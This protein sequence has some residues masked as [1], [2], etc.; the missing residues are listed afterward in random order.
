[1]DNRFSTFIS[2]YLKIWTQPRKT[3][4]KILDDQPG[5]MVWLFVVFVAIFQALMPFFYAPF[6]GYLPLDMLVL[7]GICAILVFDS[8]GFFYFSWMTAFLGRV[9]GGKGTS[10]DL[11][12]AYAWC[13]P[14]F[15][16]ALVLGQVGMIPNW[17]ALMGGETHILALIR[18][19]TPW[20]IWL[21]AFIYPLEF[22]TLFL[23]VINVSEAHKISSL[24]SFILLILVFVPT[25]IVGTIILTVVAITLIFTGLVNGNSFLMQYFYPLTHSIHP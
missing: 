17:L 9:L 23:L 18:P 24:R 16:A 8:L 25:V 3:L 1:L 22:W 20:Q 6:T 4:R 11:R 15:C 5:Y 2:L 7:I 14:P 21:R 12:T 13:C 10:K 19:Q